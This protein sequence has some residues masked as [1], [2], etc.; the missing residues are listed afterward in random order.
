M[1]PLG[2]SFYVKNEMKALKYIQTELVELN[3]IQNQLLEQDP[4][5]M[6]RHS[7]CN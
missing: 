4:S 1:L 7:I 5:L 6:K 3:S 2:D